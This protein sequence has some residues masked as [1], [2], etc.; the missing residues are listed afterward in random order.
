MLG[1][2]FVSSYNI[3]SIVNGQKKTALIAG[4]VRE[5]RLST[6]SFIASR[7]TEYPDSFGMISIGAE[8]LSPFYKMHFVVLASTIKHSVQM[9]LL[10]LS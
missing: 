5:K 2:V 10:K 6:Q 3:C 4:I 8:E 9:T 7:R 1:F